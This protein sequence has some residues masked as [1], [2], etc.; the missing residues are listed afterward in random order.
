MS[1]PVMLIAFIY[2]YAVIYPYDT[3]AE[4]FVQN[5]LYW[6]EVMKEELHTYVYFHLSDM[7]TGVFKY[8]VYIVFLGA[9]F[10]LTGSLNILAVSCGVALLLWAYHMDAVQL[11]WNLQLDTWQILTKW[12]FKF[13]DQ[14]Y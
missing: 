14:V 10:N 7:W 2:K 8:S 13:V 9:L 11:L 4:P 3:F 5:F 6:I 1:F 12:F